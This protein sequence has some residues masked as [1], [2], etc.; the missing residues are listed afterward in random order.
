[1][2][3]LK[4]WLNSNRIYLETICTILLGTMSLLVSVNSCRLT[5]RQIENDE[6]LNMP[7][8]QVK[9]EQFTWEDKNDSEKITIENVGKYAYGYE[10]NK[11]IFLKCSFHPLNGKSGKVVYLPIA[12]ILDTSFSP[13]EYVGD[14]ATYMTIKNNKY[15]HDLIRA[16]IEVK[17]SF[18]DIN[19]IKYIIVKYYDFK[20][21]LHEDIFI[22]PTGST[23][24]KVPF[25]DEIEKLFRLTNYK[26]IDELSIDKIIELIN[27]QG[28]DIKN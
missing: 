13:H 4:K 28:E 27:S 23:G 11:K 14:I 21:N 17:K 25:N 18:L 24:S 22:V 6:Y 8:I 26:R 16:S 5:K 10:T 19:L 2:K 15:Y 12:N 20:D 9:S 7:L 1:M 3:C